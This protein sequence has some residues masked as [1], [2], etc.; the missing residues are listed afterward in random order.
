[1]NATQRSTENVNQTASQ[2]NVRPQKAKI[3]LTLAQL[4]GKK[5]IR[6]NKC[7]VKQQA[8]VVSNKPDLKQQRIGTDGKLIPLIS[9]K[10]E[11]ASGSST[12]SAIIK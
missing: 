10:I 2:S 4:Q 8:L 6:R 9:K 12:E 1:M 7:S 5:F 11:T 3:Q